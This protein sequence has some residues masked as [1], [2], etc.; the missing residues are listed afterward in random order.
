[1][2]PLEA[3]LC[4]AHYTADLLG[5]LARAGGVQVGRYADLVAVEGDPLTDITRLQHI[6][7]IVKEGQV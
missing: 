3:I 6:S 5:Q 4:A 2:P 1:M 7:L